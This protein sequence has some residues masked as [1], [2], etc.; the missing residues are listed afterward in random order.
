MFLKPTHVKLLKKIM[1]KQELGQSEL[2]LE[3]NLK[4]TNLSKYIRDLYSFWFR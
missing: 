3:L 1:Q 2:G 4:K